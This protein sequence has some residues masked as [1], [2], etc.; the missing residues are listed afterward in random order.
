[1]NSC[2]EEVTCCRGDELHLGTVG[3]IEELPLVYITRGSQMYRLV[4]P[5][6]PL[7]DPSKTSAR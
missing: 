2:W 7:V 1:M 5:E 3:R 4:W 6:L